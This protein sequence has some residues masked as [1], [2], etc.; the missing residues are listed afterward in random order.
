M[1]LTQ[2]NI[3]VSVAWSFLLC[4]SSLA[5]PLI[6]HIHVPGNASAR[7]QTSL[8]LEKCLELDWSMLMEKEK[9]IYRWWMG[10]PGEGNLWIFYGTDLNFFWCRQRRIPRHRKR[11]SLVNYFIALCPFSEHLPTERPKCSPKKRRGFPVKYSTSS[12]RA[13]STERDVY[14]LTFPLNIQPF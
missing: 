13:G 5:S 7:S 3:P 11:P 6:T 12:E 1:P 10:I 9:A 2:W 4:F 14:A 8:P